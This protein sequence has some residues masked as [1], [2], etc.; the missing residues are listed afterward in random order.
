[1]R[2]HSSAE[3]MKFNPDH[4]VAA[5]LFEAFCASRLSLSV[6]S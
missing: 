3:A 4:P 1:M 2:V 6:T 5:K